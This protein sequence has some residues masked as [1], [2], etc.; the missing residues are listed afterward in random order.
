MCVHL[1]LPAIWTCQ[2]VRFWLF[3]EYF[4]LKGWECVNLTIIRKVCEITDNLDNK[5]DYDRLYAILWAKFD[6][7]YIPHSLDSHRRQET[8]QIRKLLTLY[9]RHKHI[10]RHMNSCMCACMSV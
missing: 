2:I 8:S 1:Y 4:R 9:N 7:V 6:Y 5:S 3:G 10:H